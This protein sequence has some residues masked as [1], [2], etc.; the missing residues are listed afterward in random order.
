MKKAL[1]QSTVIGICLAIVVACLLS[2]LALLYRGRIIPG[3]AFPTAFITKIAITTTELTATN[4]AESNGGLNSNR[5]GLDYSDISIGSFVQISGTDGAGLRIRLEPGIENVPQFIA[6]ENEVF[7][8]KD[9][10]EY[11]DEFTWWFLVAPY[12][13]NR[14]GWAAGTYLTVINNP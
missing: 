6:M 13:N 2:G 1:I 4:P 14:K 11:V 9:G 10:P 3:Q 12:N 8:V 5:T 7:E